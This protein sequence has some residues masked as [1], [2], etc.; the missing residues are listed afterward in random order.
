MT[1][2]RL[3]HGKVWLFVTS[4]LV[5]NGPPL[6]QLAGLIPTLIAAQRRLGARFTTA[7]MVL[8]HVGATLAAYGLLQVLTGDADGAHNR[9]LD[10][11]VSAVWLGALGALWAYALRPAR[12]GHRVARV[13]AVA[14][15]IALGLSIALFPL[16][17]ATE[18]GLAFVIGAAAVSARG[19]QARLGWLD[20]AHPRRADQLRRAE[21]C[22]PLDV[23]PNSVAVLNRR[24]GA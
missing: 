14:G 20:P 1:P 16:L 23:E 12:S 17:A 7:L 2:D 6:P 18:H 21:R 8:A 11:G 22:A 24:D 15:P 4:A 3:A 13:A 9:N 19:A 5:A 10:Y